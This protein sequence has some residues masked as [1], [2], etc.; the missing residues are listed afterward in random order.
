MYHY[1]EMKLTSRMYTTAGFVCYDDGCHLKKYAPHR[2]RKMM[3]ATAKRLTEI[4]IV[5]DK[6]HFQGHT[7]WLVYAHDAHG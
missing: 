2:D 7:G 3:T 6:L 5:V 4:N 1:G